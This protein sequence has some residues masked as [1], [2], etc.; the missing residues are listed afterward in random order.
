MR[1]RRQSELTAGSAGG[2]GAPG[3]PV[4][5]TSKDHQAPGASSSSWQ[6]IAFAGRRPSNIIAYGGAK[7]AH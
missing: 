1:R 4:Q 3:Q 2:A 7:W 6:V 5:E